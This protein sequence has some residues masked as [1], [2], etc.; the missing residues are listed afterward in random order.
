MLFAGVVNF[1]KVD[2][3][4]KASLSWSALRGALRIPKVV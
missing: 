1:L 4:K 3:L 2:V